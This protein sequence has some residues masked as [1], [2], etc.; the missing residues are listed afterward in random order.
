MGVC[1]FTY[2]CLV[3]VG[4]VGAG[5]EQSVNHTF[6]SLKQSRPRYYAKSPTVHVLDLIP[7]LISCARVTGRCGLVSYAQNTVR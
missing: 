1:A 3:C 7:D 5:H 2:V 4:C 6:I